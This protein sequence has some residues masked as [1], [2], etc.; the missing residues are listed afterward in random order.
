MVVSCEA[1]K[2]QHAC[3]S[4]GLCNYYSEFITLMAALNFLNA[5][6]RPLLQLSL[7]LL[8]TYHFILSGIKSSRINQIDVTFH[9]NQ[10]VCE[11]WCSFPWLGPKLYFYVNYYLTSIALIPLCYG[12]SYHHDMS[13]TLHIWSFKLV[14]LLWDYF[15]RHHFSSDLFSSCSLAWACVL[16]L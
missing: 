10:P 5:V 16:Q 13:P 14:P 4:L 2:K 11:F 6:A 3:A 9:K 8:Q 15:N 12:E 1:M 7:S